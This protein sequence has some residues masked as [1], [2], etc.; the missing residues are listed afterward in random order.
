MA[1]IKKNKKVI[2]PTKSGK[3]FSY[4]YTDLAKVNDYIA[5]LGESYYQYIETLTNP[6]TG[7]LVDYVYTVRISSDGKESKPLKG[8]RI[9][10]SKTS[11]GGSNSQEYGSGVTYARRYS[12]CLAY[13]LATEDDDGSAADGIQ[14]KITDKQP[15]PKQAEKKRTPQELAQKLNEQQA[16]FLIARGYDGETSNLTV[17]DAVKINEELNNKKVEDSEPATHKQKILLTKFYNEG[18]WNGDLDNITFKQA[19]N[20][21]VGLVTKNN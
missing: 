5:S 10:Q 3:E 21:L 2:V 6:V 4:N 1:N 16:D 17:A 7:E 8:C 9:V 14:V 15:A 18:K 19:S 12:L 20:V 11:T 13:G